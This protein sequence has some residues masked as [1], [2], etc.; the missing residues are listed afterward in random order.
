MVSFKSFNPF[1][2]KT[3]L[4]IIL[5]NA[6]TVLL[7]KGRPLGSKGVLLVYMVYMYNLLS[8]YNDSG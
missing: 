1:L 8:A 7:V 3:D 2:P 5:S 6:R 4:Q